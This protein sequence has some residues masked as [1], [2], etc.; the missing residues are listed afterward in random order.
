MADVIHAIRE[1]EDVKQP[2]IRVLELDSVERNDAL[3]K[4]AF[5]MKDGGAPQSLVD[6]VMSLQQTGLAAEVLR[7]LHAVEPANSLW[8]KIKGTIGL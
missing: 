4:L 3:K 2:L 5:S 1:H 7:E 6:V 8:Q